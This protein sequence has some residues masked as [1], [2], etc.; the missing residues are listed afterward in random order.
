MADE[1]LELTLKRWPDREA[2]FAL[3]RP[4]R[5]S[6]IGFGLSLNEMRRVRA[7]IDEALRLVEAQPHANA[8]QVTP[9][10]RAT[11]A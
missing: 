2:R 9:M 8:Y 3:A 11:D 6:P 1:P 7:E 5:P 4:A 10:R